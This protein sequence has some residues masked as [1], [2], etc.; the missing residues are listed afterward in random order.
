MRIRTAPA[1]F[2]YRIPR[3]IKKYLFGTRNHRTELQENWYLLDYQKMLHR[4]KMVREFEYAGV[5]LNRDF[6]MHLQGKVVV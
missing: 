1:S 4:K 2:Y 6:Y 3:K 5:E